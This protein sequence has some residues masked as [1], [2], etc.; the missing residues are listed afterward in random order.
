MIGEQCT[1]YCYLGK[2]EG[3][4]SAMAHDLRADLDQLLRQSQQ[5]LEWVRALNRSRGSWWGRVARSW[6]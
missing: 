1:G 4:I 6:R 5:C 2:L 3:D